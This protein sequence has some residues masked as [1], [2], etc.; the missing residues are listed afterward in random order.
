MNIPWSPDNDA[1][2]R[3]MWDDGASLR[4]I[5]EALDPPRTRNAVAG[6]VRR[7]GFPPHITLQARS[8]ERKPRPT[9]M[10]RAASRKPRT[11]KWSF[12]APTK[13]RDWQELKPAPIQSE[14]PQTAARGPVP[15]LEAAGRI[16]LCKWPLWDGDAEPSQRFFCG[17]QLTGGAHYCLYH[18]GVAY[19]PA[20]PGRKAKPPGR[21]MWA[22]E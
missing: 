20:R 9:K 8:F 13:P 4:V 3:T 5:A 15:F 22:A 6:R 7:L 16:G 11:G 10:P 12:G 19:Q 2:T 17:A 1:Q 18:Y 14:Q 21:I